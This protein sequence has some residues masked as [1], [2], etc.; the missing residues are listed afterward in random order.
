ML[1]RV[2]TN[3]GSFSV[4]KP[5]GASWPRLF[6]IKGCGP[7][8]WPCGILHTAMSNN[9]EKINTRIRL[10]R[11]DGELTVAGSHVC[12]RCTSGKR[13]WPVAALAGVRAISEEGRP[14]LVLQPRLGAAERIIG[15]RSQADAECAELMIMA[16]LWRGSAIGRLIEPLPE[17]VR[18]ILATLLEGGERIYVAVAGDGAQALIATDRRVMVIKPRPFG[19]PVIGIYPYARVER[20]DFFSPSP[21]V[22]GSVVVASAD[23]PAPLADIAAR[24]WAPNILTFSGGGHV[25]DAAR[26]VQELVQWGRERAGV[27]TERRDGRRVAQPQH[28]LLAVTEQLQGIAERHAHG[29]LAPAEAEAAAA[30]VVVPFKFGPGIGL[31]PAGESDTAD[32]L[33]VFAGRDLRKTARML[34]RAAGLPVDACSALVR[35]APAIVR[36]AV[37]VAV[38]QDLRDQLARAGA[39]VEVLPRLSLGRQE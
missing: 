31:A 6:A 13:E 26:R 33:L 30:N 8:T 20:V 14:V 16:R 1:S 7:C 4:G 25:P 21:R 3:S 29:E 32:V 28:L 35:A 15:F 39:Q 2:S 36:H 34:S 24:R 19:R 11:P 9:G 12:W 18:R 5:Q 17:P 10:S 22:A 23:A 38:A 37:P 27:G